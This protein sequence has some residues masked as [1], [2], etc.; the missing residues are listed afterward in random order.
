VRIVTD[1]TKCQGS[2]NC[3]F[4][5]PNTFDIDDAMK[6]VVVDPHGDPDG[7]IANAVEGCPMRALAL[8]DDED[9]G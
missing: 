9:G 6:V 2:G 8:V 4:H 7:D 5:A 1:R 3:C